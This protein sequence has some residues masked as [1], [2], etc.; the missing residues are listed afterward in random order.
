MPG[1][2]AP[3]RARRGG[4][5]H[6]GGRQLPPAP[7]EERARALAED[8]PAVEAHPREGE[9]ALRLPGRARGPAA[10][11]GPCPP[12]GGGGGNRGV[13]P[14]RHQAGAQEVVHGHREECP[15]GG[16]GASLA[17]PKRATST[18]PTRVPR[19]RLQEPQRPGGAGYLGEAPNGAH[20]AR[21]RGLALEGASGTQGSTALS[22]RQTLGAHLWQG[23]TGDATGSRKSAPG[24]HWP[25]SACISTSPFACPCSHLPVC[26]CISPVSVF[27]CLRLFPCVSI[28][29]C[30]SLPMGGREGTQCI[31]QH[32]L[33]QH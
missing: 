3:R 22:P 6:A 11:P 29:L 33:W 13:P 2:A 31:P 18:A 25:S 5:L 16:S 32:L 26:L 30:L 15:L 14:G 20:Q 10:P 7:L 8:R 12:R 27:G 21:S 19:E 24:E 17:A 1:A 23:S 28:R 9:A 4:V